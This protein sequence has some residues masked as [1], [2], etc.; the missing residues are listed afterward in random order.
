MGRSVSAPLSRAER[1][2]LALAVALPIALARTTFLVVPTTE[3]AW[4]GLIDPPSPLRLAIAVALGALIATLT[5]NLS[6]DVRR[7][8]LVGL[9][10][11]APLVPVLTGFGTPL[12]A[13][14][15]PLMTIVLLS[16]IHI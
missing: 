13:F 6:A 7:P 3:G 1:P 12:L 15:A 9:L 2:L 16:L 8:L 11:A 4:R 10:A 5:R 14:G